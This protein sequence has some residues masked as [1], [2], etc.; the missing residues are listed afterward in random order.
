MAVKA[1]AQ[2][3][4]FDWQAGGTVNDGLNIQ[5]R[6]YSVDPVH[7]VVLYTGY[8]G[9][10]ENDAASV[11]NAKLATFIKNYCTENFEVTFGLLDSVRILAAVD[12]IL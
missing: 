3:L 6:I 4:G 9:M 7:T 1:I 12:S 10:S 2:I 11:I 5:L 8:I